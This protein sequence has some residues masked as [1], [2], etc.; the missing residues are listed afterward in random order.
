MKSKIKSLERKWVGKTMTIAELDEDMCEDGS[1]WDTFACPYIPYLEIGAASVAVYDE[2]DKEE[3]SIEVICVDF[4]V[5]D[6]YD[7]NINVDDEDEIK[8]LGSTRI[9]INGFYYG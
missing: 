7:K 5:L 2:A 3:T 8:K 6:K 4:D 9:K 1:A